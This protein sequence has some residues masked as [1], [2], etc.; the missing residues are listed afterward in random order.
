M[1][2]T[3]APAMLKGLSVKVD[4]FNV[5]NAQ[6]PITQDSTYDEGDESVLSA[7]YNQYTAYQTPRSVKLT[8]E[9]NKRF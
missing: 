5:F 2:L 4:V 8:V 6:R 7:Y 1:N 9:Y 3:Y